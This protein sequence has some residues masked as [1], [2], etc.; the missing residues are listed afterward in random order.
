M[1]MSVGDGNHNDG[2]TMPLEKN[3]ALLVGLDE[4]L[5]HN[6][7][8]QLFRG[9]WPVVAPELRKFLNTR[10]VRIL[11]NDGYLCQARCRPNVMETLLESLAACATDINP[12]VV[13]AFLVAYVMKTYCCWYMGC[14]LLEKIFTQM[15]VNIYPAEAA[16]KEGTWME[17]VMILGKMYGQ[18]GETDYML[19]A[20]RRGFVLGETNVALSYDQM[21]ITPI[22]QKLYESAMVKCRAGTVPFSE[23]EFSVWEERWTSAAKSLQQWDLLTDLSKADSNAELGLECLWRLADWGVGETHLAASSMLRGM[24]LSGNP[25]STIINA[26]ASNPSSRSKFIEAFLALSPSSGSHSSNGPI[27]FRDQ[28]ERVS[29]FQASIEEAVQLALHEWTSLPVLPSPAHAALLHMFQMLVE[30][31]ES[32]VLYSNL[33]SS[34]GTSLARPQFL[35]D[36]KGI[37]TAWRERLPNPWDDMQVWSDIL[38][39]RQHVFSAMNTAFAPLVVNAAANL[40]D[41]SN[42]SVPSAGPNPQQQQ[43]TAHPFAF[44]GYHEMAWLINKFAHVARKNN[45][46]DVCL[47]FLNRIYTLPNIEIQDA[48]LKLREQAKCYMNNPN[49]LPTALEV[50]NA[51]NLNYFSGLQ[52]GEFFALRSIILSRLGMLEEANRVFAQAVQIDLNMGHGWAAWGRFNDQRF[53]QNQDINY[54]LNAINCYLQAATLFRAQKSRRFLA[55]ILWLLT[56]EDS[57]GSLAKSFEIYNHDL[58]T[59]FWVSFVPQLLAAL[60]R[61]EQRQARFLLI[62]IAKAYPQALYLP[63][64]TFHEDCRL[65]F[66]SSN[67]PV[68]ASATGVS[69]TSRSTT[70]KR[71]PSVLEASVASNN[72]SNASLTVSPALSPTEIGTPEPTPPLTAPPPPPPPSESTPKKH[73]LELVEELFQILKTG[74]P[75]LALTMENVVEHIVHRLRSTIDEEF[76]RV[77]TSLIAEAYQHLI[78]S[79]SIVTRAPLSLNGSN[80]HGPVSSANSMM[81]ASLKRVYALICNS[82]ALS[83][84]YKADFEID[85]MDLS[86][87]SYDFNQILERLFYWR[88][89]LDPSLKRHPKQLVLDG[90]SRFLAEFEYHRYDEIDVPGQYLQVTKDGNHGDFVKIERFDAQVAVIR[91]HGTSYRRLV[92]RGSDGVPYPFAVQNPAGRQ[93]RREERIL[94]MFRF[95]DASLRRGMLARRRNLF[96]NV[97]AIVPIAAHV[98]LVADD[99]T[100]V[101]YEEILNRYCDM[102]GVSNSDE[103]FLFFKGQLQTA[104]PIIAGENSNVQLLNVRTEIFTNII[105]NLVPSNIFAKVIP[106]HQLLVNPSF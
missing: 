36:L 79:C 7:W 92:M 15:P 89:K 80:V 81:E 63:L 37:L 105:S 83:P 75:L 51:T 62:K 45:L 93:T 100:F 53:T 2:D 85:F 24:N 99:P 18:L 69:I 38:A 11:S 66:A 76:Y 42:A 70:V 19:G 91:R 10:I 43:T 16:T 27:I 103:I 28:A 59:W 72:G 57:A 3:I 56:F 50:V 49:D 104:L 52:K 41:G 9:I 30:I 73:P 58:P 8:I 95:L 61:Q 35:A 46:T 44:R 90:L 74:Y 12:P 78:N 13:P 102:N 60:P 54:A 17:L 68:S 6:F 21:D 39:W 64:R 4:Q 86:S 47:S 84:L 106:L 67:A 55:R 101:S 94:Q 29:A 97:P 87:S 31:Q 82:T 48:F 88:A 33:S 96:F 1:Y 20:Y 77:L 26:A 22:A 25:G 32:V 71:T 23:T 98:R 65:S 40:T 34:S 5:A 14:S